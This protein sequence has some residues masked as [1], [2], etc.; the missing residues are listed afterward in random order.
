MMT[1]LLL[2]RLSVGKNMALAFEGRGKIVFDDFK[3]FHGFPIFNVFR[4]AVFA[5]APF[6]RGLLCGLI[7][8]Y[9]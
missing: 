9:S 2:S 3:K 1:M 5:C 4:Y 6:G 7:S 8:A